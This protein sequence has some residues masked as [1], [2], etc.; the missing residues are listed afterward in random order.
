MR[1]NSYYLTLNR[2]TYF[3]LK[4]FNLFGIKL[5]TDFCVLFTIYLSWFHYKLDH[6]VKKC[7]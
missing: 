5:K 3:S 4:S 7:E 2:K 6:Y 1:L